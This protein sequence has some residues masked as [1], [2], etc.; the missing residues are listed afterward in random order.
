[1]PPTWMPLSFNQ[2]IH[3]EHNFTTF[4]VCIV[5]VSQRFRILGDCKV[6]F[7]LGVSWYCPF[8]A[9]SQWSAVD[10]KTKYFPAASTVDYEYAHLTG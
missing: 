6:T 1:M 4:V 3:L 7:D 10:K 9:P 8:D 2:R 5:Q